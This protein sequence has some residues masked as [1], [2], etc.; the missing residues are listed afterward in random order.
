M[1]DTPLKAYWMGFPATDFARF[2]HC[3]LQTTVYNQAQAKDLAL[4]IAE[5]SAHGIVVMDDRAE[6]GL[7]VALAVV[8]DLVTPRDGTA[9]L[10]SAG[11]GTG[12]A[13]RVRGMPCIH[14]GPPV[15]QC[16]PTLRTQP[17]T[18]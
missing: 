18:S 5:H 12:T 17:E 1:T 13:G 14:G 6:G 10:Y 11:F 16:P 4:A 15:R 3:Q 9:A 7:G 8:R 2:R